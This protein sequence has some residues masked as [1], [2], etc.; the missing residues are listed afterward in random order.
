M[1]DHDSIQALFEYA[2]AAENYA[3]HIYRRFVQMFAVEPKVAAFWQRY[4]AEERGHASWLE[5]LLGD[6]PIEAQQSPANAQMLEAARHMVKVPLDEAL[7]RIQTL[8][9]AYQLAHEL[10]NSEMNTVFGFIMT[11]FAR[12]AQTAQFVR[13]QLSE[14]VARLLNHFPDPFASALNRQSVQAIP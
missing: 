1:P 7:V 9:D 6:L 3:E 5:K 13:K 14:H 11:T 2:I 12:D 10:E 4:A 8:D